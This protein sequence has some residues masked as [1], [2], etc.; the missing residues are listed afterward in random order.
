M[1]VACRPLCCRCGMFR[2]GST[3]LRPA[4]H[5]R[6][7][8]PA[9]SCS[10]TACASGG[11]PQREQWVMPR[12][13]SGCRRPCSDRI[14]GKLEFPAV[15]S[16]AAPRVAAST[17]CLAGS[18][19]MQPRQAAPAWRYA[20]H[21]LSRPHCVLCCRFEVSAA[22]SALRTG[23]YRHAANVVVSGVVLLLPSSRRTRRRRRPP[24]ATPPHRIA[25]S[26]AHPENV[27][28]GIWVAEERRSWL[29]GFPRH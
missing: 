3:A 24:A 4:F 14:A 13:L 22:V 12:S 29:L 15:N 7:P 17:A 5:A 1:S 21:L 25:A 11:Q 9:C 26:S 2:E 16:N 28:G 18:G 23:Q 20:T 6:P 19:G 10:S 8:A 27:A